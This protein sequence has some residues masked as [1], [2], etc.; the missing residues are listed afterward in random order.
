[1]SEPK[2]FGF[3]RDF[4][5]GSNTSPFVERR[6]VPTITVSEHEEKMSI[7]DGNAFMR[8]HGAG[9]EAARLEQ[10]ARLALATEELT[11]VLRQH[12]VHLATIEQQ[13]SN[14]S[15][16]FALKFSE[17]LAGTLI[18]RSPL[19]PIEAAARRVFGDLRGLP[20]IAVRV[21][22]D[23]VEAVKNSLQVIG[24][25]IGLEARIIVLGEPEIH[26]SD[27]R[28]EWADGGII[29]NQ[30]ALQAQLQSAI[31]TALAQAAQGTKDQI[32]TNQYINHIPHKDLNT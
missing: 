22:P 15:L 31:Q 19:A 23:L 5:K 14:E 17:L 12:S 4:Q 6:K 18:S 7:A 25:E 29:T 1:M 13:A 9:I 24:R 3:S 30:Q 28:I 20:H 2:K 21:A 8:G 32:S 26:F 16:N 10:T 27:C 11:H